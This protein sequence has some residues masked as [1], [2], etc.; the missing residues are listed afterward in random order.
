[1]NV[2]SIPLITDSIKMNLAYG[3]SLSNSYILLK[4]ADESETLSEES[5]IN[6]NRVNFGID[7]QFSDTFYINYLG[8]YMWIKIDNENYNNQLISL[9]AINNLSLVYKF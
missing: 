9:D 4:N 6:L 2:S 3:T 1:L 8:E 7:F 5:K